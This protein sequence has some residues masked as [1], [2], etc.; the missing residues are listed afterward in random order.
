MSPSGEEIGEG[1]YLLLFELGGPVGNRLGS[2]LGTYC[3]VGSA[4][5]PGGLRARLR[6][7]LRKGKAVQW[8]IDL[9]TSSV[10]FRPISVLYSPKH[11]E[12]TIARA[13]DEKLEGHPR[14]GSSDCRCPTHLFKIGAGDSERLNEVVEHFHLA[15]LCLD[16]L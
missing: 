5:G 12:C 3:Y 7:H 11:L 8:H 2:F 16:S 15:E 4:F 14:F 6:R 13:L 9:L 1:T 10:S